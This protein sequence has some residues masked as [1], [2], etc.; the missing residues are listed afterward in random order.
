MGVGLASVVPSRASWPAS[1]FPLIFC[2]SSH[3]LYCYFLVGPYKLVDY[4]QY[5]QYVEVVVLR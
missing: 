2:V 5:E 3:F 1:L 4:N